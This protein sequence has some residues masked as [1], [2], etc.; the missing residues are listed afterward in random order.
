MPET[1]SVDELLENEPLDYAIGAAF[2]SG[3]LTLWACAFVR[4]SSW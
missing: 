2:V 3:I 4:C 1:K